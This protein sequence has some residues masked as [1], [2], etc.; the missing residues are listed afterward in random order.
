M[1]HEDLAIAFGA[2]YQWFPE[3]QLILDD[4]NDISLGVNLDGASSPKIGFFKF[5][6]NSIHRKL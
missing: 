3:Q 2:Q 4:L 6:F 5:K 1:S